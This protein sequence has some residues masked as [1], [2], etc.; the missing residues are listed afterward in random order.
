[1]SHTFL[2][3]VRSE[4]LAVIESCDL[5]EL[6]THWQTLPFFTLKLCVCRIQVFFIL[7]LNM[8]PSGV[9]FCHQIVLLHFNIQCDKKFFQTCLK[10]ALFSGAS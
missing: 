9:I 7:L 4:L 8:Y 1:M 10:K 5:P 3:I 2:I 6:L